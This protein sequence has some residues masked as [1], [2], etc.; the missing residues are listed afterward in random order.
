MRQLAL[1]ISPTPAPTL[2][3][4]VPGANA[5]ILVRLNA[6]ANGELQET[7]VYLWGEPGSGR[8]H[9]LEA[10]SR[11]ATRLLVVADDVETL[12]DAQQAELFRRINAARDSG[13]GVLAA[14]IAPP[15]QLPLRDDLRS[16]LGWGLVYHVKPLTDADRAL[17]LRAQADRRGMRLTDEVVGYLLTHERRD[18]SSLCAI[19]E[20]LDRVSLERQRAV[21]L[22]LLREALKALAP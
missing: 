7:I 11:E 4:F 22:P 10:T 16:R 9:L 3:N 14:G 19:I 21:T 5:E 2:G 8:S 18:L 17:Y 1:G 20:Q 15:A 12:D 6:L 13:G